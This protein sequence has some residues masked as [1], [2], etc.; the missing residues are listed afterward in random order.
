MDISESLKKKATLDEISD[1]EISDSS[2][3]S[4]SEGSLFD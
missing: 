1:S 3:M 2:V 4:I